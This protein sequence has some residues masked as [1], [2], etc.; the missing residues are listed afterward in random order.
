[1]GELINLN[2]YRKTRERKTR[3][4]QAAENRAKFGRNKERRTLDVSEEIR[5]NTDLDGKKIE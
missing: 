3:E 1:M 2:R 4:A 5:R